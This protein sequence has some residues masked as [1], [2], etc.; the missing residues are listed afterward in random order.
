M[1]KLVQYISRRAGRNISAPAA[2][3]WRNSL[4][5]SQSSEKCITQRRHF[6]FST[7]NSGTFASSLCYE[8]RQQFHGSRKNRE[9]YHPTLLLSS[10]S[11]FQSQRAFRSNSKLDENSTD[12]FPKAEQRT[13]SKSLFTD[14]DESKE[15]IKIEGIMWVTRSVKIAYE[16]S[17]VNFRSRHFIAVVFFFFF[18]YTYEWEVMSN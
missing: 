9:I 8:H 5:I 10:N 11:N 7:T 6:L 17:L 3:S 15:E 4:L 12:S 18:L 1:L 2:C 13:R 14:P 16:T